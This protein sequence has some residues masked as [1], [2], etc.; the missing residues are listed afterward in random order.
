VFDTIMAECDD[1]RYRPPHAASR[2]AYRATVTT[3]TTD[4]DEDE[5]T[6]APGAVQAAAA[7]HLF[8][9]S[10]QFIVQEQAKSMVAIQVCTASFS[11]I[12]SQSRSVE[13]REKF[14][15]R[16][17]FHL[18]SSSHS[19]SISY[20]LDQ[21]LGIATG[22]RQSTLVPAGRFSRASASPV[23]FGHQQTSFLFVLFV[24][25]VVVV[26]VVQL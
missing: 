9:G 24:H 26:F 21:T 1:D 2:L 23:D 17:R 12:V 10:F 4:D 3:T 6:A 14:R 7:A 15:A 22:S 13:P 25:F 18:F 8:G 20:S 11:S 5:S 19:Y 16:T